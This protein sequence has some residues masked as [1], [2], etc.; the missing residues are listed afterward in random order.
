MTNRVFT[1]V[2]GIV[3]LFS[4]AASGYSPP[5][6]NTEWFIA[7]CYPHDVPAITPGRNSVFYENLFFSSGTGSAQDYW[8]AQSYGHVSFVNSELTPWTDTGL[9]LAQHKQQSR[10]ENIASCINAALAGEDWGKL[11][12]Y[13]YIAVYNEQLDE[14]STAV[15]IQGKQVPAVIIDAYSPQTGIMHEMGHGFGLGHSF[16]DRNAEYGD[17]F[18]VM[19]AMNVFP[20]KGNYCVPSHDG[21]GHAC[22][23]Q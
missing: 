23:S 14:G 6:A 16:N 8:I 20:Y 21:E 17:P 4:S 18:D 19:S 1:V 7:L 2:F 12:F 22:S 10:A 5:P 15:T 3:C 11:N 13:N 9:T